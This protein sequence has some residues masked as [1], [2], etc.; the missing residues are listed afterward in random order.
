MINVSFRITCIVLVRRLRSNPDCARIALYTSKVKLLW[1]ATG[2]EVVHATTKL[3]MANLINKL[4]IK[5]VR[6]VRSKTKQKYSKKI[7]I[8]SWT[9]SKFCEIVH[10]WKRTSFYMIRTVW[11]DI[12]ITVFL[13]K[14][15]LK[16]C[17]ILLYLAIKTP[18]QIKPEPVT[19]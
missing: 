17:L 1:R 14:S 16:N 18:Q 12:E 8:L 7:V 19:R 6:K 10:W 11:A 15:V 9:S 3:V 2:M 4:H 5:K 13:G